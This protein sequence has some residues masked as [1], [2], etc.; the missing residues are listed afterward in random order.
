VGRATGHERHVTSGWRWRRWAR[1]SAAARDGRRGLH[2]EEEGGDPVACR[3]VGRDR[4]RD[5]R[6]AEWRSGLFRS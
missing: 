1:E 4:P 3:T 6:G 5:R 2:K